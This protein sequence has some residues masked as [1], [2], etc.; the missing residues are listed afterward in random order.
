MCLLNCLLAS[1]KKWH[2]CAISDQGGG[3]EADTD[4][5]EL[6]ASGLRPGRSENKLINS[7]LQPVAQS[8]LEEQGIDGICESKTQ[9]PT[10]LPP[11][12]WLLLVKNQR[13]TMLLWDDIPTLVNGSNVNTG[14]AKAWSVCV[15][16]RYPEVIL[17]IR[18][19]ERVMLWVTSFESTTD[20]LVTREPHTRSLSVE[21]LHVETWR[22]AQVSSPHHSLW[23]VNSALIAMMCSLRAKNKCIAGGLIVQDRFSHYP[24]SCLTVLQHRLSFTDLG[25]RQTWVQQK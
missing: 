18:Y 11:E 8:T 14:C 10:I 6:I 13:P 3:E 5:R 19:R 24:S 7:T 15:R 21:T 16:S 12:D 4:E 25:L 22:K 2:A 9:R 20:L 1:S 17:V 23:S